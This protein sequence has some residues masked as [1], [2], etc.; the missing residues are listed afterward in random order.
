MSVPSPVDGGAG[1]VAR[2]HWPLHPSDY[3]VGSTTLRVAVEE[4]ERGITASRCSTC[5]IGEG[6]ALRRIE[7]CR[8]HERFALRPG[9]NE[10]HVVLVAQGALVGLQHIPFVR[11]PLGKPQQPCTQSV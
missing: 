7:E 5:E 10:E 1:S 3:S 4:I 9:R 6:I 11:T 2:S 8:R